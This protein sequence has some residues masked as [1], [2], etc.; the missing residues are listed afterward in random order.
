[1]ILTLGAKRRFSIPAAL[2]PASSGDQFEATFDAEEDTVT[3]PPGEAEG[4]LAGGLE[5]VPGADG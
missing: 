5:K 2:A 3:L 1:M 4:E